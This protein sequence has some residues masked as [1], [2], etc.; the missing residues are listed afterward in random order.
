MIAVKRADLGPFKF[1][2]VD[3]EKTL[4]PREFLGG[5]IVISG[6]N[7]L[8]NPYTTEDVT[9]YEGEVARD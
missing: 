4:G 7:K 1:D 9:Y 8:G 5:L 6:D 3:L 2:Q